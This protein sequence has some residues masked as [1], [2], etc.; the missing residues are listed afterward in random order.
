MAALAIAVPMFS[1]VCALATACGSGGAGGA[2]V[3]FPIVS[4][5]LAVFFQKAIRHGVFSA[6]HRF[7]VNALQ[8]KPETGRQ[9]AATRIFAAHDRRHA[10]YAELSERIF[11]QSTH[12]RR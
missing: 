7:R 2:G 12:G 11:E 1:P 9:L 5:P 4:N 3:L 6:I 10:L 8:L